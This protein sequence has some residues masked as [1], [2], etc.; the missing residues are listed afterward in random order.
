[1]EWKDTFSQ[2][3]RFWLDRRGLTQAQLAQKI[4]VSAQ[5][6]TS[7]MKGYNTPLLER[8]EQICNALNITRSELLDP[9]DADNVVNNSVRINVYGSIPAG[10]PFEAIE[11]I[12]DFE[13][14]PADWIKG[15]KEYIAL[16]VKGDSMYPEYLD[17][18]IVIILLQSDFENGDDCAVF[19]NGYDATLKRCYKTDKGIRLQPL[20]PQ[21]SP[22]TYGKGDTPIHILGIVKEIRRRK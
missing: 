22:K 9:M 4:G 11:D 12:Q 6:I 2:N 8:A 5:T 20:N 21:Y 7:Y 18:D 16:K 17:G 15:D 14:I 10:I 19:V 1:M 13:D 3:L